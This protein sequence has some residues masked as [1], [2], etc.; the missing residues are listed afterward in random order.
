M[1]VTKKRL[2][3]FTIINKN[4]FE[5]QLEWTGPQGFQEMV[6]EKLKDAKL[7][8]ELSYEKDVRHGL[9][10]IVEKMQ[11]DLIVI[12]KEEKGIL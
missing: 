2:P 8:F 1:E 4:N 5:S 9:K 12:L 6:R 7:D 11:P 10:T 3:Y